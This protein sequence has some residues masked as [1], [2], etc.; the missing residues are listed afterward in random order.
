MPAVHALPALACDQTGRPRQTP[1]AGRLRRNGGGQGWM[2]RDQC[3]NQSHVY[4]AN[5]AICNMQAFDSKKV[6]CSSPACTQCLKLV[7]QH[8]YIYRA[9]CMRCL[10]GTRACRSRLSFQRCAGCKLCRAA[11][12]LSQRRRAAAGI[13]QAVQQHLDARQHHR[14][15][16]ALQRLELGC[17]KRGQRRSC[18]KCWRMLLSFCHVAAGQHHLGARQLHRVQRT[19]QRH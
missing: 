7:Y 18:C 5:E 2:R 19:L 3:G 1:E 14:V 10:R 9:H 12:F 4:T 16:R 6:V 11:W 15:R 8:Q 13:L 17:R